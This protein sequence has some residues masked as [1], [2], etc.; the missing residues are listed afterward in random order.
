[1]HSVGKIIKVDLLFN[2]NHE[3]NNVDFDHYLKNLGIV[4][5]IK[6]MNWEDMQF[7]ITKKLH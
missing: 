2:G 5:K 3:T 1:M 6:A 7:L 4:L